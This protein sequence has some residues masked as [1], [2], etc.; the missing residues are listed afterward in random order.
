MVVPAHFSVYTLNKRYA[1][2]M[3]AELI[4]KKDKYKH[5]EK[6]KLQIS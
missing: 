3:A 1:Q 2:V 6:I 4:K 5:L